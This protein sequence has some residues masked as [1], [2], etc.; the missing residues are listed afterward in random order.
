MIIPTH[1]IHRTNL[2]NQS[3]TEK[4][5]AKRGPKKDHPGVTSKPAPTEFKDHISKKCPDCSSTNLTVKKI[6]TR[7]ITE[8]RITS[9]TINYKT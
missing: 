8:I 7:T 2:L 1:L 9:T 5:N 3:D 4:P 6:Q